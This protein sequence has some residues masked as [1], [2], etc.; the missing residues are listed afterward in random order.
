MPGEHNIGCGCV[1]ESELV[2]LPFLLN[3]ID[4]AGLRALNEAESGSCPRVFKSYN[5]RLRDDLGS[6][7]S[8]EDSESELIVHVPFV[9]PSHI[10]SLHVI[11]GEGDTH[12]RKLCIYRDEEQLD[13]ASLPDTEPT[14]QLDLVPDYHGAIEYPLAAHKFRNVQCLALHF[15]GASDTEFIEIFFIGL[16]GESTG[17]KR[18][19]VVTTYEAQANPSDHKAKSDEVSSPASVL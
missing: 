5:D 18:Q 16:R 10:G 3:H 17:Y 19:A 9:S 2:G 4:K 14:Q 8:D 13:F 1:H 7:R 12:P 15:D 6:C 11:G